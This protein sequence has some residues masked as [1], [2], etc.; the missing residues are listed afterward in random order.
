MTDIN[1]YQTPDG[2]EINSVNGDLEQSG[3][4][5]TSVYLLLFGGNSDDP[6]E[7]DLTKSWWGNAG[8]SDLNKVY[9]SRTQ[10][11]L[12]SL[13]I[14]SANLN[15]IRNAVE[16]DLVP[17]TS[18]GTLVITGIGVGIP[19]LNQVHIRIDTET[20]SLEYIEAWE[21]AAAS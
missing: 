19:G 9:R 21:R 20:E 7:S 10:Y 4:L 15:R 12:S 18:D 14:N 5:A 17:L 16:Q 11:L 1:L 6:G 13:P 3:G 2:G 8:E